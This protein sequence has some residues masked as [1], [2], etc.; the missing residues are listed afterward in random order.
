MNDVIVVG[1]GASGLM[2]AIAAKRAGAGDVTVLEKNT[3]FGKKILETGNGRCNFT[4]LMINDDC[5]HSD[6]IDRVMRVIDTFGQDKVL[7]F[8]CSLGIALNY[9]DGWCYPMSMSASSVQKALV[10]HARKLGISLKGG[11]EVT[12]IKKQGEVF[13]VSVGDFTYESKKVVLSCGGFADP[14]SGSTGEGFYIMKRCGVHIKKPLPALVPLVIKDNPLKKAAGVRTDAKLT[15][16][17]D[18]RETASDT[19][20]LQI[21]EYGVSGIP[22]F[23]LSSQAVRA[24]DE[25]KETSLKVNFFP[26]YPVSAVKPLIEQCIT[27]GSENLEPTDPVKLLLMGLFPEKLAEVITD[28]A[29]PEG[30][31][32]G[33]VDTYTMAFFVHKVLS[34]FMLEVSGNKG[35]D[36]AQT[37][38][39]G[40]TFDELGDDLSVKKVK[41]LYLCGEEVDADGLCGGYNLQWAFSSGYLAGVSAARQA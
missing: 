10:S 14:K 30:Q 37:T 17:I 33:E 6:D 39:G 19:G 16:F 38:S 1:G 13:H 3:V 24:V 5:Y 40:V 12:D 26:E 7:D 22:V 15:L 31:T 34:D 18:G 25:G 21:T 29:C 23:Q 36:N 41:G 8:F 4:N 35:F 11:K 2:A 20:N 32:I 9:R 28:L 27:E